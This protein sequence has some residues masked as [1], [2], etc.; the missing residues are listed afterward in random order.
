VFFKVL[1]VDDNE[2]NLMILREGLGDIYDVLIAGSGEQ[3]LDIARRKPRPDI[4]LLDI[5]M[6]NMDGYTVIKKLHQR[7]STKNIPVIFVTALSEIQDELHGL[8]LGAVDY[9]TKPI[10]LG[11]LRRRIHNHLELKRHRDH[12][13]EL[14]NERTREIRLVQEL[15]I[16]MISNVTEFR[17]P[18]TGGHII[19]TKFYIK[20]LA[21][22]LNKMGYYKKELTPDAIDLIFLSAPLHDFGKVAIPDTILHKPSRLSRPEF[23]VMKKHT[24]YGEQIF[25]AANK[26]LGYDSFLKTAAEIAASHH[27]RWDGTGYPYGLKGEEIPLSGRLMALAD[28]YDALIC[29]RIY[30]PPMSHKAAAKLILQSK[31]S[32]FAPII[33]DAFDAIQFDFCKCAYDYAD[34]EIEKRTLMT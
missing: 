19:R 22:K 28:V 10:N 15:T 14:V 18:E 23:E 29:R 26:R 1:V 6:P 32:H 12:L 9:I 25:Q 16:E 11:L 7:I 8:E 2:D 4:I 13:Q 27:E 5:Q 31:G 33:I 20:L 34:T 21:D 3:A 24:L 30:K 17:D